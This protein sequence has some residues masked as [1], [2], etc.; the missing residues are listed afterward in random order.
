MIRRLIILLLIVGCN[1]TTMTVDDFYAD[2][3]T[4][5]EEPSIVEYPNQTGNSWTYACNSTLNDTLIVSGYSFL[6][7]IDN[8]P[9]NYSSDSCGIETIIFEKTDSL[10]FFIQKSPL[11]WLDS[12]DVPEPPVPHVM[13]SVKVETL[14]Y[15]MTEDSFAYCLSGSS[16]NQNSSDFR[17]IGQHFRLSKPP[18]IQ[19]PLFI[20]QSWE[21]PIEHFEPRKYEVIDAQYVATEIKTHNCYLV[22]MSGLANLEY[23]YYISSE[24]LIKSYLSAEVYTSTPENPDGTGEIV[25]ATKECILVNTNPL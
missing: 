7:I 9:N 25:T 23:Y 3:S 8:S 6:K 20:G 4:E 11:E 21:E 17:N 22:K 24:G 1:E 13:D 19:Y 18:K 2:N 12:V 15:S 10:Y 5:Y 16:L 14:I